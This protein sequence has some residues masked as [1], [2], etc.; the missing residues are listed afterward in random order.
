M[1]KNV[2]IGDS[3]VFENLQALA[4]KLETTK[5]RLSKTRDDYPKDGNNEIFEKLE[6]VA[7]NTKSEKK[8]RKGIWQ[9]KCS[10]I[11]NW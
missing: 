2:K 7:I 5:T 9:G 3:F 8:M 10:K 6:N 11:T 1:W 4:S